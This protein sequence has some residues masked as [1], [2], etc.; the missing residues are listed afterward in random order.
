MSTFRRDITAVIGKKPT[1]GFRL[2]LE[3]LVKDTAN[4]S[5]G[6]TSTS[7]NTITSSTGTLNIDTS[8][9]IKFNDFIIDFTGEEEAV[10]IS[11]S[12][13]YASFQPAQWLGHV[14]GEL[15][16]TF[17]TSAPVGWIMADNGT[18]GNENS[19]AS[20]RAHQDCQIL[21]VKFWNKYTNDQCPVSG[22][23]GVSGIQD[24]DAGKTIT[25]PEIEAKVVACS[26]SGS[27][28]TVRTDYELGGSSQ[29]TI[30]IAEMWP[31]QH[32]FYEN[33]T[34]GTADTSYAGDYGFEDG[35]TEVS[36]RTNSVAFS[37]PVNVTPNTPRSNVQETVYINFMIKL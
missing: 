15:L 31:H 34:T 21:F 17:R 28:L 19:S 22:G 18:I 10:L 16:P 11:N 23:R 4:L 12:A 36:R 29:H 24:F 20:L 32:P 3:D 6:S 2:Y 13:T 8:G 26:G 14:S 33:D 25:I 30:S 9:T 35:R 27:G 5:A 1:I 7:N 37:L